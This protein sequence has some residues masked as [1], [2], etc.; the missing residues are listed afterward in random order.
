MA[1]PDEWGIHSFAVVQQRAKGVFLKTLIIYPKSHQYL[2]SHFVT[3]DNNIQEE[4]K[5][6]LSNEL[7]IPNWKIKLG[8]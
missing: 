4:G 5:L 7:G 1:F 3:L 6:T 8:W 2:R